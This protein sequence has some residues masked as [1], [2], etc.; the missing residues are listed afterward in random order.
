MIVNGARLVADPSGGLFWPQERL[1]VVADL[2]FEKGSS[3]AQRGQL[4]PPYDT[5]A[6]LRRLAAL[7]R[8]YDPQ[9]VI[10]LGDSFH[11]GEADLRLDP[12]DRNFIR[13]MTAAHDWIWIAGNHDPEPPEDLG[14]R[15]EAEVVIGPL[16]FRHAPM[17][18]HRNG[19]VAGEVAG[20]LHP[21]AAVRTRA[22]RVTRRC[23][24]SD[25]LRLVLPAFGAYTGGLDVLDAAFAAVFR[26]PFSAHL[27]GRD[28]TYPIPSRRLVP[29]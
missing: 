27:L 22:R 2:H 14:G 17:A 5:A 29:I 12:G 25:G 10:C 13:G 18:A 4:L 1:L 24:A 23:F 19:N 15:V 16:R 3:F 20:H 11:D 6:T 7:L 9:T 8:Q 21:K 28:R 26:G